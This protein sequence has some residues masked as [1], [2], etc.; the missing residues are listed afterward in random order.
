MPKFAANLS[1]LFT[2]V[3]F[4]DR[5]EAAAEA[6][7]DGVEYLFPYAYDKAELAERLAANRLEQ[8]LFNLPAGDWAQGERG[9][10]CLPDRRAE[11]QDGVGRAIDYAKALQVPQ[12]NCLVGIPSA[13]APRDTTLV[14]IVENLRYAARQAAAAKA[15]ACWWSPATTSTSRA[16]R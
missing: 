12:L 6:G 13:S 14:T 15:S 10:A 5:F 7:F 3:H 11:F 2:E 4:L 1:M 16:S 9:I 8:V